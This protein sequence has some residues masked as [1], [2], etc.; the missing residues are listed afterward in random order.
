[1]SSNNRVGG[2]TRSGG[3]GSYSYSVKS[4]Y[5]DRPV[6]FVSFWDTARFANWMHNGQGGGSTE[7][8]AYALNGVAS[9]TGSV[10]REAGAQW[11]LPS[12]TEWYK[13]AYYD[14]TKGGTGGYWMQATQSDTL[15][16]N[17]DFATVS[18]RANYF[19]NNA[20]TN[21]DFAIWTYWING[22]DGAAVTPGGAYALAGS[23]YGTFD[24]GGNVWELTDTEYPT[25]YRWFTG[26]AWDQVDSVLGAGS[27]GL[28]DSI[29]ESDFY[30]M[31][32]RIA[33][34][35]AIPEPSTYAMLAGLGALGLAMIRRRRWAPRGP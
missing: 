12:I 5:E 4:G 26:G 15:G 32:F 28:A 20:N 8:G 9:P 29:E 19:L 7:T 11:F 24:Q 1:M 3:S 14:P 22:I 6:G 16:G 25:N 27:W 23:F 13:A 2:I 33:S 18:N 10:T 30:Y 31:G 35:A 34:V 21:T 17:R